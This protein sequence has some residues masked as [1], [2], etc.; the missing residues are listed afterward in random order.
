MLCETHA[1]SPSFNGVPIAKKKCLS[2]LEKRSHRETN[3]IQRRKQDKPAGL[4][5]R[6]SG[7]SKRFLRHN[8]RVPLYYSYTHG[9]LTSYP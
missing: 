1:L 8:A 5:L 4:R 7:L 2:L 9:L 6:R 3:C